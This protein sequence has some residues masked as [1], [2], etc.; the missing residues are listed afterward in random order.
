M[1]RTR[2]LALGFLGVILP[3]AAAPAQQAQAVRLTG[4]SPVIDGRVEEEIWNSAPPVTEFRQTNPT[5]GAP[6][7][8]ATEIRF[9]YT[10]N[11]LYIG[12]RAPDSRPVFGPLVRR[13]EEVSSDYVHIYLDTF[14]DR[15]TAY[16][17]S[18]NPAGSRRD[19]F[20][21]DDGASRDNT[22]DPVYD[23]ATRVTPQGWTAELRIPFSQLRFPHA[24]AQAFGLRVTRVIMRLNEES[25]WP[26]FPRDQAGEVSRYGELV[27]LAGLPTPRRVELLPYTA[28]SRLL[29]RSV[30]SDPLSGSRSQIRT[31]ADLK[32]GLTS[33]LTM[34][35]TI[36]P[37]F[38]QVEADAAVVNLSGFENFF[39]EK[40]P[41]FV[42]GT[43]LLRF[44]FGSGSS[45]DEGLVY[46]RRIGRSPQLSPSTAG[47]VDAPS[48]TTILGA[49][50]I[51]GKLGGG[52]A[53]GAAQALTARERADILDVGG[54]RIGDAPVEPLSS[55][56]VIRLQR[57]TGAGRVSYSGIATGMVRSFDDPAF[58]SVLHRNA[59]SAGADFRSRFA[60]DAY[61]FEAKLLGSQVN[62]TA[63]SILRTQLAPAHY[64]QRP[65]QAYVIVDS[66]R[67]S[68]TGFGANVRFAKVA[69]FMVFSANAS[70]RSPGLETNDVG[71][72]RRGDQ[73]N[74]SAEVHLR[75][76]RPGQVLPA[77]RRFELELRQSSSATYGWERG[78]TTTELRVDATFQN[79]WRF[80]QNVEWEPPYVD[81][82][83]L[84]GG[85]AL[86]VPAHYHF[87]G[88]INTDSRRALTGSLSW[89]T[90]VEEKSGKKELTL[91]TG[92]NWRP[93]G[94]VALS[95]AARRN[96]LA[97][98][99]QYVTTGS[100]A[101]T[102]QFVM[103][104][105]KRR[106]ISITARSDISFSPR[107]SLQLYA[108]PFASARRFEELRLVSNPRGGTY[109]G[110]FSV[111]GA[112]RLSR[113]GNGS[114]VQVD[115]DRDGGNDISFAE[116]NRTVL[117]LR[118]NAVLRWEFRPGSTVYLVW[119]QNRGAEDYDGTLHMI[120]DLGDTFGAT[121]G[122]VL[123]LKV[124]WW[125]GL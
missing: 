46:T 97:E 118:T 112:D 54:L 107:L 42:E 51:T 50:K 67:T 66:A 120:R 43:D 11:A 60:R 70:T 79:Y 21:Y 65:D 124:S 18:V 80:N 41:F 45:G 47:F 104:K 63:Q 37:D 119:N 5:E 27:G 75:W 73:H 100:F 32:V 62:G 6:S 29:E 71:F 81:T 86:D 12:V 15:R 76:L 49:A 10:D 7:T 55:Y 77:F 123:A 98:D 78:S 109:A 92:V 85:P 26:Y 48:E 23:W 87:I 25:S 31:G 82:R 8:E 101:G 33:G 44:S 110:Q 1:T 58:A 68:L 34:D 9:L 22:W 106:E 83:A 57:T 72:I 95:L 91:N 117:S 69:G 35:V 59:F 4:E 96:W 84:R 105:M 102:S 19:T 116:P 121:G 93:P 122:H 113:G 74:A 61:E 28:G 111:L 115:V 38:G 114:T 39:A 16:Q 90:T 17:F 125:I 13:D 94:P 89:T 14:H 108:Q 52:W 99:R 103:G 2:V 88:G 3:V 40:R 64:F 20:I 53:L 56:S 24:D 36:N 30:T